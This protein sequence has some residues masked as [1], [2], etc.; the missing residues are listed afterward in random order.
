LHLV[1]G[2]ESNPIGTRALIR[3]GLIPPAA[4]RDV[5]SVDLK[6]YSPWASGRLSIHPSVCYD[7]FF[8]DTFRRYPQ[9]VES[10]AVCCLDEAF[11]GNG[12]FQKLSRVH[13]RL[14]AV[15]M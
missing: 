1:T 7:M 15:E 12:I 5:A 8:S 10:V 4:V 9:S 2:V 14:R 11:D 6:D 3:L 13:T